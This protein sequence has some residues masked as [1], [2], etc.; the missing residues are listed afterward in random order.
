MSQCLCLGS[1]LEEENEDWGFPPQ[2]VLPG[3]HIA[4]LQDADQGL[5]LSKLAPRFPL[6]NNESV[7]VQA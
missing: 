7:M 2:N 5:A 1:C 4:S 3:S 6:T